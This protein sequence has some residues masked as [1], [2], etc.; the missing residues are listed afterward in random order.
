MQID[1]RPGTFED[2][3]RAA[4]LILAARDKRRAALSQ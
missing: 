1:A 4:N 3:A 2:V